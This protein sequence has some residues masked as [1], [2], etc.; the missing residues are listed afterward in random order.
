MFL[1]IIFCCGQPKHI[2]TTAIDNW[3][4]WVQ[5]KVIMFAV[6]QIIALLWNW[7][8]NSFAVYDTLCYIYNE[9]DHFSMKQLYNMRVE[10]TI[11][12]RYPVITKIYADSI[13]F[14]NNV[15]VLTGRSTKHSNFTIVI[16]LIISGSFTYMVGLLPK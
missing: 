11:G 10:T 16:C 13:I 12:A 15:P 1:P 8:Y 2:Y 4:S 3:R 14:L 7:N 9:I 6:L 5:E